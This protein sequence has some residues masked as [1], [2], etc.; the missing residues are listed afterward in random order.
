[1]GSPVTSVEVCNLSLDLLRH[2]QLITSIETPATEEEALAARWYDSIRRS[3]LRMFPWNFARLRAS[4]SRCATP[5]FGYADAYQLPNDFISVVFVGEDPV[6]D[7]ETDLEVEGRQLLID[8]D[9]AASLD[10]CYVHDIQDV[11]RFDPIFLMLLVAELAVVFGN[12][13]TGL[14]K[15]VAGM[16]KLRDRWEAKARAKNGH[17]NP[18]RT[19]FTSSLL[20]K[21]RGARRSGSSDGQHLFS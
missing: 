16:E 6:D 3:S 20:T 15:S 18:P 14:N 12:S 5:A 17:E 13:I 4:I 2:N 21:R 10:L 8:N 9:G 11:V 7:V 19:R 1:M